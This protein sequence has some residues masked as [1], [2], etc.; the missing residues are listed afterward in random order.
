MPACAT[1]GSGSSGHGS[2]PPRSSPVGSSTV[3]VNSSGVHKKGDAWPV[4]TSGN[5]THASNL[6]GGSG[7]VFVNNSECGRIG[8]PTG[9]GGVVTSGSGNVYVA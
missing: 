3:F 8:D 4:H 9:C 1:T 5:N 2:H 6:S 7:T